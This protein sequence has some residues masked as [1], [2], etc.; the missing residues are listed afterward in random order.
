[1]FKGF[2]FRRGLTTGDFANQS[3]IAE[4]R[5]KEWERRRGGVPRKAELQDIATAFNTSVF[6]LLEPSLTP[7]RSAPTTAG[8]LFDPPFYEWDDA[9]QQRWGALPHSLWGYLRFQLTPDDRPRWYPVSGEQAASID[10]QMHNP[11]WATM[12]VA[13]TS[14]NRCVMFAPER[15]TSA[16]LVDKATATSRSDFSAS[17]DADGHPPEIYRALRA[18]A[19]NDAVERFSTSRDLAIRVKTILQ[20]GT[21]YTRKKIAAL[22]DDTIVHHIDGRVI[23]FSATK[24]SLHSA[25]RSVRLGALTVY[26]AE[27][28]TGDDHLVALDQVRAIDIP[29]TDLELV[30]NA[31]VTG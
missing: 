3:G 8:G 17:W 30:S 25:V 5:I 4:E 20:A 31:I 14:N 28:E 29:A 2:R 23:R 10:K 9:K 6:E 7:R 21:T 26:L 1:M 19:Q 22:V 18:W 15:V 12:V 16:S 27:H 11:E 13:Q 24:G